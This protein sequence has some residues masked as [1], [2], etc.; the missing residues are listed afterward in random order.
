VCVCALAGTR[1]RWD[2]SSEE[3]EVRR[4]PAWAIPST[5]RARRWSRSPVSNPPSPW[6]VPHFVALLRVVCFV[7]AVC[8][9]CSAASLTTF[10]LLQVF[11]GLYPAD[12][13][14]LD[15]LT[16]AFEKLTLNDASV[17][18]TKERRL[19]ARTHANDHH[20]PNHFRLNMSL[21]AATRSEWASGADSWGSCTWTF[22]SSD[23][24]RYPLPLPPPPVLCGG[25]VV[26]VL[27]V[28]RHTGVRNRRDRHR[29][30]R[31]LHR[32]APLMLWGSRVL[33][34][35]SLRRAL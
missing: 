20:R 33:F 17:T 25:A 29:A 26:R 9:V 23:W 7:R 32:Y 19:H 8:V 35:S 18:Y 6:S 22:S 4:R 31:A 21:P 5:L 10:R 13:E 27:I 11:A 28:D 1:A 24:S 15:R 30:D 14:S 34:I 3:C 12:G 2:T 16:D